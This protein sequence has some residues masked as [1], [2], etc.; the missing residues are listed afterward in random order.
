MSE[1]KKPAVERMH[2]WLKKEHKKLDEI[3]DRRLLELDSGPADDDKY[4][5]SGYCRRMGIITRV[6]NIVESLW[7]ESSAKEILILLGDME[8]D[9]MSKFIC[10]ND[11]GWYLEMLQALDNESKAGLTRDRLLSAISGGFLN[12][13]PADWKALSDAEVRDFIVTN[14]NNVSLD[15]GLKEATIRGFIVVI[16]ESIENLLHDTGIELED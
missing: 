16:A 5:I 10:D 11:K 3:L 7:E 1:E 12:C 14:R 2:N 8:A 4:T 9:E 13:V 15:N 6:T